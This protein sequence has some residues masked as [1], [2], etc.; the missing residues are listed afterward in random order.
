MSPVMGLWGKHKLHTHRSK[1]QRLAT[2]GE[3]PCITSE[4]IVRA[5]TEPACSEGKNNALSSK[6][7]MP[8]KSRITLDGTSVP[9]VLQTP[10]HHTLRS[11]CR[12]FW[13]EWSATDGKGGFA[14]TPS[15]CSPGKEE[16]SGAGSCLQP[17]SSTNKTKVSQQRLQVSLSRTAPGHSTRP[18]LGQHLGLVLSCMGSETTASELCAENRP[19][20]FWEETWIC[21]QSLWLQLKKF[22][23]L[24]MCIPARV[25]SNMHVFPCYSLQIGSKLALYPVT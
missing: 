3:K 9:S 20:S 14:R 5:S 19:V 12:H 8:G 4:C 10:F 2:K 18:T 22:Y 25:K 6:R 16:N 11:L 7:N 23:F 17:S 1:G 15:S 13:S 21:L 24:S